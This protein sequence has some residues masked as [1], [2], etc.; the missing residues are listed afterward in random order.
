[1]AH[2]GDHFAQRR[3]VAGHLEP[4]VEAFLHPQFFLNVRQRCLGRIHG[5]AYAHLAR[6]AQPVRIFVGDHYVPRGGVPHHGGRHDSD[7]A[8]AG[9]HHVL[10]QNRE[11]QGG[12]DGIAERIEDRGDVQIDVFLVTPKVGHRHRDVIGERARPIHADALDVRAQMPPPG[13]AVAAAAA[14]HVAFAAHQIARAEIADVGAHCHDLA[15]KFMADRHRHGDGALR[16]L[17]PVV[18]MNIGAADARALYT[19]QNIV[20]ADFRFANLFEPQARLPLALYECLH[21]GLKGQQKNLAH[22]HCSMNQALVAGRRKERPVNTPGVS[23][24]A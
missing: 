8:R 19:D 21:E 17:V 11:R 24:F 16:P 3:R 10:A 23:R 20:D 4:H 5:A 12:M 9:D 6:Q 7:R 14:D 13:Q 22:F 2:I 1:M 15:H 18:D